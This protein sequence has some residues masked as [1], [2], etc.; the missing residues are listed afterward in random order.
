MAGLKSI[1]VQVFR[2]RGWTQA[3]SRRRSAAP[4]TWLEE[5]GVEVHRP[6]Q[7]QGGGD[8]HLPQ[9]VR[10]QDRRPDPPLDEPGTRTDADSE[11]GF[12]AILLT[13]N[14]RLLDPPIH[15]N[16][17]SMSVTSTPHRISLLTATCIVIAN[18]I[19]TGIFTSLGFQ[20][21]DLPSGFAI[22]FLWTIGGICAMCGALSSAGT[23]CSVTAFGRRIPFSPRNL[24]SVARI[25]RRLDLGDG[26]LLRTSRDR[27]DA[28]RDLSRRN[29]PNN[30]SPVR[31]YRIRR[32]SHIRPIVRSP[33]RKRFPDRV[34]DSQ[35]CVNRSP[36]CRRSFPARTKQF[37]FCRSRA[38]PRYRERPFRDQSLLGNVCL[39]RLERFHI[40][41]RR[42]SQ[43]T[44][45][46]P[47]SLISGTI[48]VIILYVCVN[49]VFLQPLP[50]PK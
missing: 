2:S 3:G 46:F 1:Q 5:T 37:H 40:Y 6:G 27:G 9:A 16:F 50:M 7:G 23:R 42:N 41:H 19:G 36:Y 38:T 24:S 45:E 30:K 10:R 35:G 44:P 32:V 26:R 20:V 4:S 31:R 48:I 22:V 47:L 21:G 14:K 33:T 43:S 13:S 8:L 34:H 49:A 18:M 12:A 17:K 25:S 39:L 28:I 11:C 15:L 29:F